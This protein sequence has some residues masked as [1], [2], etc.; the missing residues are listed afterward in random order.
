MTCNNVTEN[1][2]SCF[3]G[4]AGYLKGVS[5]GQRRRVAIGCELI[6]HPTLLFLDEPTSGGY[7]T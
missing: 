2:I 1:I 6:T 7:H 5:G 3:L 4:L